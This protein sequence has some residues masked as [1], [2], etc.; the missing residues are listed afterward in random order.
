MIFT[1]LENTLNLG[2]FIQA[3][4]FSHSNLQADVFGNLFPPIAERGGE[5]YYLLHQNA[6]RKFED[7]LEH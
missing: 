4:P 6:I 7:D 1:F 5:R 3:C 2:I